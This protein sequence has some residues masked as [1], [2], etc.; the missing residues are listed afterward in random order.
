M[1]GERMPEHVRVQVLRQ[2]RGARPGGH[3]QL[4]RARA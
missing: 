2:A 4:H 3:A 1:G